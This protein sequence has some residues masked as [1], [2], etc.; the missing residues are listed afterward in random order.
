MR[1]TI[2]YDDTSSPETVQKA[3]NDCRQWLG[4]KQFNK[5]V[6]L[7]KEDQQQSSRYMVTIGLSFQGIEGYPAEVMIDTYWKGN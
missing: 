5:V 2:E 4:T 7:L 1:Y 6:R 3:L